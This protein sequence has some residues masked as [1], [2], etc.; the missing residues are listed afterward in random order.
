MP[1]P[2]SRCVQPSAATDARLQASFT[3]DVAFSGGTHDGRL[4]RRVPTVCSLPLAKARSCEPCGSYEMF[5]LV[6][7]QT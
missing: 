7:N 6:S 4:L 3:G 1:G 2:A 5:S